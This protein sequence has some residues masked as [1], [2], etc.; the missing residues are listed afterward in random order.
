MHKGFTFLQTYSMNITGNA[1]NKLFLGEKKV[2]KQTSALKE[3]QP[4]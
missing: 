1:Q 3:K 4:L 2:Q